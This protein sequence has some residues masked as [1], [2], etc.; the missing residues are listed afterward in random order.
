MLMWLLRMGT[1]VWTPPSERKPIT[2][3]DESWFQKYV[4]EELGL[5]N[6]CCIGEILDN[7]HIELLRE[8]TRSMKFVM[9]WNSAK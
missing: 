8:P 6:D 9:T 2:S 4:T 3:V 5:A 7:G 1:S